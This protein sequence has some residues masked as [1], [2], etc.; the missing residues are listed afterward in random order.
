M[1]LAPHSWQHVGWFD[2]GQYCVG[3]RVG[4]DLE[5]RTYQVK[6]TDQ[7]VFHG[8]SLDRVD[9]VVPL[10]CGCAPP[11]PPVMR[12]N[13][14]PTV[15]PD[16]KLP[17][18]T[19]LASSQDKP[20][21]PPRE[22]TVQA[23]N[24]SSKQTGVGTEPRRCRRRRKRKSRYGLKRRSYSGR[25][26]YRRTGS[27]PKPGNAA[28]ATTNAAAKTDPTAPIPKAPD[29]TTVTAKKAERKGFFGKIGGFFASIFK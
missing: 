9:S 23:A 17:T 10:E 3:G 11:S 1:P 26:I 18:S 19:A 27:G 14:V 2:D 22:G 21:I 8:G 5:Y 25:A 15:V 7:L 4:I 20:V 16:E 12:A 13:S 28:A 6:P 24:T 29:P